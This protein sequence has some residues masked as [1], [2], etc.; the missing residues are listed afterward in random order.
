MDGTV[1]TCPQCLTLND[2]KHAIANTFAKLPPGPGNKPVLLGRCTACDMQLLIHIRTEAKAADIYYLNGEDY[3][4]RPALPE[5][6]EPINTFEASLERYQKGISNYEKGEYEAAYA[7]LI[8]AYRWAVKQNFD[9][10]GRLFVSVLANTIGESLRKLRYPEEALAFINSALEF[11]DPSDYE[12]YGTILNNIGG[13]YL[14]LGNLDL[15]ETYHREAF[16]LH[17]GKSRNTVLIGRSR[18]NL[19]F[20]Y[21][22]QAASH[23]SKDDLDSATT[24]ARRS[25]ELEEQ[26]VDAEEAKI[27]IILLG[28]LLMK[29]ANKN[30]IIGQLAASIDAYRE[31][32]ALHVR[33]GLRRLALDDYSAIAKMQRE[34]GLVDDAVETLD[35]IEE[36]AD[37]IEQDSNISSDDPGSV[38]IERKS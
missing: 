35:L 22:A 14:H 33:A 8:P 32:A 11:C 3:I 31:A 38:S 7:S 30:A 24:Y 10:H 18:S 25:F 27:S 17:R 36:L 16:E 13:A 15:A 34:L 19:C 20:V 29:T 5:A 6:S 2:K 9:M 28:N 37:E 1:V 12:N 4:N 26:L 21:R 23:A